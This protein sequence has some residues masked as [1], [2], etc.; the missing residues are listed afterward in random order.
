MG[1]H[2]RE[3][4]SHRVS[5]RRDI[6]CTTVS[7]T[8]RCNGRKSVLLLLVISPTKNVLF[9]KISVHTLLDVYND[10]YSLNT[11]F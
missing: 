8:I 2:N 9:G 10:V 1:S 3:L 7:L 5:N 6:R 11:F 4:H